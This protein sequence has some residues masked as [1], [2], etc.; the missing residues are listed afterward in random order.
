MTLADLLTHVIVG[1]FVGT[2][3]SWKY[4]RIRS[5]HVTM[6]MIGAALPDLVRINILINSNRVSQLTGLPFSWTPLHR[7]G[8]L[9]VVIAIISLMVNIGNKKLTFKLLGIGAA[10]HLFIDALMITSS[11]YSSAMFWPFLDY[12]LPTP[13]LYISSDIHL[14]IISIWIGSIIWYIDAYKFER[15]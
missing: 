3:L 7:L 8:G 11:G 13:G 12:R 5:A 14:A 15:K 6:L 2:V 4:D 1:Y 10:T 9:L